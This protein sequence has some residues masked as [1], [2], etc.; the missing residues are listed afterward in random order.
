MKRAYKDAKELEQG[1]TIHIDGEPFEYVG[2]GM[3]RGFLPSIEEK[4]RCHC[5]KRMIGEEH[6]FE[7]VKGNHCDK[8][9]DRYE[10]ATVT[11]PKG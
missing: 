1:T 9:I 6:F 8:C 11:E 2:N 4:D 5:S 3:I 7:M 10:S